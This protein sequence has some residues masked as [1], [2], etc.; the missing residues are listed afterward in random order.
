MRVEG[1]AI[2]VLGFAP[3]YFSIERRLFPGFFFGPLTFMYLYHAMGYGIGP[4]GQMFL[5]ESL[6]FDEQGF[7]PA[8]WGGVIG[9]TV[10]AI[11]FPRIFQGSLQTIRRRWNC[12]LPDKQGSFNWRGYT[13]FIMLTGIAIIGYDLV[14]DAA[15]RLGGESEASIESASLVAA[16]YAVHQVMFFF[17]AYLAAKRGGRWLSFWLVILVGYSIFFFLEGGRGNAVIAAVFSAMGFAWA[18]TSWRKLVLMGSVAAIVFVPISGMVLTYRSYFRDQV[19]REDFRGRVVGFLSAVEVTLD[20]SDR[21]VFETISE[22]FLS[23]I[24]AKFVDQV[25]LQTPSSIPFAGLEGIENALWVVVPTVIFPDRPKLQDG[26]T[27]AIQYDQT[28][29]EDSKGWY[30]PAVGEGYRRGGWTGVVLLYV[31]SAFIF[32]PV[33][34]ICWA[35][36]ANVVWM[37]MF[38]WLSLL[39]T[40]IWSATMLSNFWLFWA[41][42]RQWVTF[43][44]LHKLQ[45]SLWAMG[46]ALTGHPDMHR[47]P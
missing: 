12:P 15:S 33:L 13:I 23:G 42:P 35:R 39:A 17:L 21:V 14:S 44:G 28:K 46:M 25:F 2:A 16:F 32:G 26:N 34:A 8:Q 4:L 36:R 41:F 40:G 47:T 7:V 29:R 6:T 45:K 18:G 5:L 9:L 30:M 24:T 19:H 31:F 1:G 11:M 43:W 38:V 20:Q 10:F 22:G 27:L 37:S 3:L